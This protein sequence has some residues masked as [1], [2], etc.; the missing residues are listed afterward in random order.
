MT[1]ASGTR[2]IGLLGGTLDPIHCGHL[3]AAAAARDAL[4]PGLRSRS[5][6]R[7]FRRI[8]PF[9]RSRRRFTG[10]RWRRS[11][12]T[13]CPGCGE[14][15][16]ASDDGTVVH[17]GH[18]RPAARGAAGAHRRFSSS[19]A[20]T[21]LQKSPPGTAIPR[22]S[23]SRTSSWSRGRATRSMRSPRGCRRSPA[24]M[25]RPDDVDSLQRACDLPVTGGRRRA[26]R[27]P[28][29]AS[30]SHAESRSAASCRRSSRRTSVSTVSIKASAAD[31]LHGQN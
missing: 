17:G 18:A 16:R 1:S 26:S 3:D 29:S 13:A 28:T 2:R 19:P 15:R 11:R 31:Q 8:A 30:A 7:T 24:R 21:R 25:R 22:S 4:S 12:S 23:I 5:C 27:P 14:R 6:P 10:S 20:P 9:S